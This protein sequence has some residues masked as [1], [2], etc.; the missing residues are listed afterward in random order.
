VL[1]DLLSFL[2]CYV[3]W[4]VSVELKISFYYSHFDFRIG[5]CNE[6]DDNCDI[7]IYIIFYFI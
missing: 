6:F 7:Y 3:L 1:S 2:V 4:F 5:I